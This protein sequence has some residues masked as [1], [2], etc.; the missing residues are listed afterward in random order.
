MG[1]NVML[2][3]V[4]CSIRAITGTCWRNIYISTHKYLSPY[5]HISTQ[6]SPYL[7]RP[8]AAWLRSGELLA[9]SPC[10]PSSIVLARRRLHPAPVAP[11]PPGQQHGT[12]DTECGMDWAECY[13]IHHMFWHS[14][15]AITLRLSIGVDNFLSPSCLFSLKESNIA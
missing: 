11:Q 2:V 15:L 7:H 5:L 9:V 12:S 13:V 8:W 6:V 3:C 14:A 10:V 1:S 4:K